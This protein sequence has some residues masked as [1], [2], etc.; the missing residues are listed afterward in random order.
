MLI[1]QRGTTL[2]TLLHAL[3][4]RRRTPRP[5]AAARRRPRQVAHL[6]LYRCSCRAVCGNLPPL[7][8]LLRKGRSI[9]GSLGVRPPVRYVAPVAAL[10]SSGRPLAADFLPDR[11]RRPGPSVRA[12][13]ELWTLHWP[14][15]STEPAGFVWC[16]R[17]EFDANGAKTA[18][19]EQVPFDD[20]GLTGSTAWL[21]LMATVC[22]VY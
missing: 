18:A 8:P 11:G 14:R 16:L 1:L 21:L 19:T 10:S 17:D 13:A 4:S 3:P 9:S 22:L 6:C 12:R 20:G 7:P 5:T 2:P 15:Q